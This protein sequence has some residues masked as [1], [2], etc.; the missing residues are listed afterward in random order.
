MIHKQHKPG[1]QHEHVLVCV[2]G[3]RA[4]SKGAHVLFGLVWSALID[5][6]I[7]QGPCMFKE[8]SQQRPLCAFVSSCETT[9]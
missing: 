3:D 5:D 2:L 9:L 1:L 7:E 6:Q 4:E 8:A